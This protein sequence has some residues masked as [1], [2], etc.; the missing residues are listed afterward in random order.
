MRVSTRK[1]P[2]N[3]VGSH[4]KNSPG[5]CTPWTRTGKGV[6]F[7]HYVRFWHV[8]QFVVFCRTF[9]FW[10]VS[11]R[12]QAV[13]KKIKKGSGNEK[14]QGLTFIQTF[15]EQAITRQVIYMK[16]ISAVRGTRICNQTGRGSEGLDSNSILRQ[17]KRRDFLLFCDFFLIRKSQGTKKVRKPF[18][19]FDLFLV[20]I[21]Y[22]YITLSVLFLPFV[23][24]N[25]PLMKPSGSGVTKEIPPATVRML[26]NRGQNQCYT[27]NFGNSSCHNSSN[28]VKDAG[29]LAFADPLDCNQRSEKDTNL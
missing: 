11:R 25:F 17:K 22:V 9:F 12:L 4:K 6:R 5:V 19:T 20:P 28:I 1:K 29:R 15:L 23:W 16:S 8:F 27:C 26:Q 14:R 21:W 7:L 18:V 10:G 2:Q 3:A 13:F 24:H